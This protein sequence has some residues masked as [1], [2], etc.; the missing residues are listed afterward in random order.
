M[1]AVLAQCQARAISAMSHVVLHVTS[2][3]RQHSFNGPFSRTTWVSRNQNVFILDFIGD[4]DDGLGG[5]SWSCKMCI[6]KPTPNFLQAGS[7]LCHPT[8]S[9]RA[10]WPYVFWFCFQM[11]SQRLR[12]M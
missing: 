2:S 9:V 7:P 3:T 11:K 1:G 5:D 6:N 10:L 8:S 4:K 12:S